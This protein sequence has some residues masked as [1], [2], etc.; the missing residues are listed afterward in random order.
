MLIKSYVF[1]IYNF[2][3]DLSGKSPKFWLVSEVSLID[4]S[5]MTYYWHDVFIELF[6]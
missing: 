2:D 1:K 4:K 3:A 6:A 5:S